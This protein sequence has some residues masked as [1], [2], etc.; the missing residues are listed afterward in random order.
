MMDPTPG[1]EESAR[2]RSDHHEGITQRAP[3]VGKYQAR[4]HRL[5]AGQRAAT[6]RVG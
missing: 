4:W 6:A 1:P 5:L 3:V 2:R